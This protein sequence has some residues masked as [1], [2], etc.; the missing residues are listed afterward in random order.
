VW[1]RVEEA[2]PVERAQV[3]L[4]TEHVLPAFAN[5]ALSMRAC[6]AASQSEVMAPDARSADAE[7]DAAKGRSALFLFSARPAPS[8]SR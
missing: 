3:E 2:V 1:V 4:V 7:P 6:A 5:Q 8:G